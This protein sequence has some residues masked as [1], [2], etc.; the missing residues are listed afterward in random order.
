MDLPAT[1]SKKDTSNRNIFGASVLLLSICVAIGL[2]VLVVSLGGC[3]QG[4]KSVPVPSVS[5]SPSQTI[6]P[7]LSPTQ[8]PSSTRTPRPT[9]TPTPTPTLTPV[10][11]HWTRLTSGTTQELDS[12]FFLTSLEGWAAGTNATLLHTINGGVSWEQKT[13]S[14]LH[15]DT[16]YQVFFIGQHGWTVSGGSTS[17]IGGCQKTTDGGVSWNQIGDTNG[18]RHGIC[19]VETNEGWVVGGNTGT[20]I[21]YTT[22]NLSWLNQSNPVDNTSDITLEKIFFVGTFEGW[23]VGGKHTI[24]HTSNKG[25]TWEAQNSGIVSTSQSFGNLY[26]T[27]TLEG[28]VI[29]NSGRLLRTTNG[30]QSWT[31]VVSASIASALLN[32]IYFSNPATGYIVGDHGLIYYS[33]DSGSN[34]TQDPSGVTDQL[35]SVFFFDPNNGWAVGDNGRILKYVP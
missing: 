25:I 7:T 34:W 9:G 5:P 2:W 28:F 29:G 22:N 10:V 13:I 27:N 35:I 20:K 19:F 14:Q 4:V 1:P 16:I 33:T 24:L 6:S 17:M 3:A 31:Q 30:G 32:G 8:S 23:A 11:R 12:V 21:K 18:D 26:F 15:E